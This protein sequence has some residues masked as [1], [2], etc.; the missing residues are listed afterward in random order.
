MQGMQVPSLI[1]ELR[2]HMPGCQKSK[3]EVRSSI[4]T[5]S[6]KDFKN[7][8]LQ[9]NLKNK[10][11]KNL[12]RDTETSYMALVMSQDLPS[13]SSPLPPLPSPGVTEK[14]LS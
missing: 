6:N 4:V 8:P 12:G 1:R 13:T 2:I 9:K 10:A 3:T 11:K 14:S 7:G 5:K